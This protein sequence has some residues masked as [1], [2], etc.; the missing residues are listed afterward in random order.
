MYFLLRPGYAM[1]IFF[2][3]SILLMCSLC[4]GGA[5]TSISTTTRTSL[6]LWSPSWIFSTIKSPLQVF[7]SKNDD[8]SRRILGTTVS[9]TVPNH[10]NTKAS[11]NHNK[12]KKSSTI[13]PP[14]AATVSTST[15]ATSNN[16]SPISTSPSAPSSGSTLQK[17]AITNP[18]TANK[19]QPLFNQ[20][21]DVDQK[22]FQ[23]DM[24][25]MYDLMEFTLV[26]AIMFGVVFFLVCK[27]GGDGLYQQPP[28]L[29]L[30]HR[31]GHNNHNT[32]PASSPAPPS[33]RTTS[34]TEAVNIV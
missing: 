11:N 18:S 30:Q 7:I 23:E 29:V 25:I 5:V 4:D 21:S 12:D 27:F 13:S 28:L 32:S 19:P 14:T 16:K 33:K 3:L 24:I 22:K 26:V 10:R 2:V 20:Q 1:V 34:S 17:Q 31:T 15:S 6:S 8:S 9:G